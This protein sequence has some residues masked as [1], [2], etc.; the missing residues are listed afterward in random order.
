MAS[1]NNVQKVLITTTKIYN[2]LHCVGLIQCSTK[3]DVFALRDI[4]LSTG[5][6][7][8]VRIQRSLT[9]LQEG[10]FRYATVHRFWW[11]ENANVPKVKFGAIIWLDVCP[12]VDPIRFG[13]I[14]ST[15]VNAYQGSTKLTE[16]VKFVLSVANTIRLRPNAFPFVAKAINSMREGVS[17]PKTIIKWM[18]RVLNALSDSN[19]VPS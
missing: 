18:E 11:M 2:A 10:A 13:T 17:A 3:T 15:N 19:T 1:A 5:S 8:N 16:F 4:T 6:V 14:V 12:F 9:R 7:I